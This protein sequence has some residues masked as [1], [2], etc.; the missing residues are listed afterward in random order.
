MV[1]LW[2]NC[3]YSFNIFVII[4]LIL[5][6]YRSSDSQKINIF[7][8]HDATLLNFCQLRNIDKIMWDYSGRFFVTSTCSKSSKV[9]FTI[10]LF[11]FLD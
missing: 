2:K 4:N 10:Y 3:D 8:S 11:I 9:F 5:I 7:D 6:Y 1:K